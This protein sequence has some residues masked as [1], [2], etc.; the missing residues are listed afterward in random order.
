MPLN[1][2]LVINLIKQEVDRIEE[3]CPEYRNELL[4]TIGDILQYKRDHKVSAG[5][6]QRN[7]SEKCNAMSK[8]LMMNTPKET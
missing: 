3:R 8:F 6:V 2:R 4:S 7:I 1:D 5:N